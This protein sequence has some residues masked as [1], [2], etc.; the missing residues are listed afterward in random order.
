MTASAQN[1]TP[2]PAEAP[3]A[4]AGFST[5]PRQAA[6]EDAEEI[7]S[8]PVRPVEETYRANKKTGLAGEFDNTEFMRLLTMIYGIQQIPTESV[9]LL[10]DYKLNSEKEKP[11]T[12]D[13]TIYA[14]LGDSD[15]EITRDSITTDDAVTPAL[16]YKMAAAAAINPNYT[17]L[18]LSGSLEDRVMLFMAAQHFG[19]EI[20]QSSIP[21]VPADQIGARADKFRAFETEAGLDNSVAA[22]YIQE[23]AAPQ[24]TARNRR[25]QQ[26]ERREPSGLGL[27]PA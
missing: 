24:P 17:T 19:M 20:D 15:I 21:D 2:Q 16:A 25:P 12:A 10:R 13:G 9:P 6:N 5:R 22:Q 1:E 18:T 27:A 11:T 4:Y 23:E 26:Q 3:Q 8:Q 14:K 7:N